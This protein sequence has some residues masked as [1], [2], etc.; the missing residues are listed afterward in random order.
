MT[1]TNERGPDLFFTLL[2]LVIIFVTGIHWL[3]LALRIPVLDVLPYWKFVLHVI[4]I[5]PLWIALAFIA[6]SLA[7]TVSFINIDYAIKLIALVLLGTAIQFS[8]AYSK[9]QGL[10]GIRNRIVELGHAEFANVAVE[11]P[12]VLFALQNYEI[13]AKNE[14]YG[15]IP[16]KPPGTLLFYMLTDKVSNIFSPASVSRSDKLENLR[17]FASIAWPAI[18]Y[19]VVIPL[20]YLARELFKN[21]QTA[22]TT[23]LFYITIPSVNLIT[24]HTDQV[25]YPF[26][27]VVPVLMA[28]IAFRKGSIWF[29]VLCGLGVYLAVYFSFGLAVIGFLLLVPTLIAI[30]ENSFR[31][32]VYSLK[33]GVIIMIAGLLSNILAYS[34]LNYNI[35]DRYTKAI[36]HHLHWKVWENRL[37][38][39]L[40]AG[41]TDMAEFSVWFG[42]PLT[43]LFFICICV[44]I[45]QFIVRNPNVASFYNAALVGIFVFLL[46]FGR[47]KAETARLWLFL[48]PFICISVA[49]FINQQNWT[50]RS[51]IAFTI[52]I[53]LLEIGTTYFT[54]RY[55]DF[56]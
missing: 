31:P 41:I 4:P 18:S 13:L 15:Y 48:V 7:V 51:K 2:F 16:S 46:V 10:D 36:N 3:I 34:I 20:Y 53:L 43:I 30:P 49:N 1:K 45:H 54:L 28:V 26:L 25:I 38:T 52:M 9:G 19:F 29:A 27:A 11:Q 32:F 22:I 37:G 17:T 42:L 23:S 14:H 21:S 12:G 44:S 47:T 39:Y 5:N 6:F 56:N 35:V 8:F 55:Q 24:L 50:S 33:Y 40:R